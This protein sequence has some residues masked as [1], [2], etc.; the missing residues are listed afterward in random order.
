LE[1]ENTVHRIVRHRSY[2]LQLQGDNRR[3]CTSRLVRISCEQPV[4]IR[5]DNVD[6]AVTAVKPPATS[7]FGLWQTARLSTPEWT[8]ATAKSHEASSVAPHPVPYVARSGH[9]IKLP[10]CYED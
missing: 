8:P 1:G 4:I 5:A 3:W 7:T 6:D 9:A 2:E 10:A